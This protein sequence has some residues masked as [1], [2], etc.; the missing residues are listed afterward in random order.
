MSRSFQD[1]SVRKEKLSNQVKALIKQA[2]LDGE[3]KPGDKLP[4][5][6]LL[7]EQMQVSKVTIREALNEL[8]TEG[9]IEKRRGIYGGSFVAKPSPDKIGLVM[10]NFY[11]FSG[12]SPEELVDFRRMIEPELVA[13]AVER[14]SPEDLAAMEAN[15]QEV[16]AAINS[17]VPDQAKGIDFHIL[18]ANACHNRLTSA[19]MEAL[20]T[21][22]LDVLSK[23]PMTL[24][25]ARG[26]LEYNKQFYEFMQKG[27][28][29]EARK[30]MIEH[31]DTLTDIIKRS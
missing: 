28:K 30:L 29:Q 31:F 8:E 26:D 7:V 20:V 24:E 3:Y 22:F 21:V 1:A 14:R 17:G 15:I 11:Q 19:I 6:M 5:E 9:I 13:I 16:E 2:I 27:Q 23:V 10:N 4:P 25:D 12:L 18:I